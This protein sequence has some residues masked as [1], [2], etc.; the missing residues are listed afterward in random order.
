MERQTLPP[1]SMVALTGNQQQLPLQH[2]QLRLAASNDQDGKTK[3]A[4]AEDDPY[5]GLGPVARNRMRLYSFY[6]PSLQAG[7]YSI[8]A[9]QH[10]EI[11]DTEGLDTLKDK[12][13]KP[14]TLRVWNR[15]VDPPPSP[16][17][18]KD[19]SKILELDPSKP[20]L[21]GPPEVPKPP[22]PEPQIFE[23]MAPQFSLDPKLVDS[24]YPPDGHQDE[25]NTL[26]HICFNDPHLPWER[27]AGKKVYG[28]KDQEPGSDPPIFRSMVPWL[29]LLVF[30]PRELKLDSADE[31]KALG[32]PNFQDLSKVDMNSMENARGTFAM[33]VKDYLTSIKSR[34][35]Y[36]A[37]YVDD[38][39]GELDKT[40]WGEFAD[41]NSGTSIIFPKKDLFLRM[42]K[43][44][45]VGVAKDKSSPDDSQ[46][47]TLPAPPASASPA[48]PPVPADG[49]VDNVERPDNIEAHKYLAHVRHINATGCPDA[50][51]D[52]EG[53]FSVVISSRTGSIGIT[54]PTPQIC[55]LVSIEHIDSTFELMQSG[56]INADSTVNRI[57]LVSLFSWIYMV[58]P[59]A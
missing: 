11:T 54:Q 24:Y 12:D 43:N 19:N 33:S 3:A 26:P 42:F 37:A 8:F 56:K 20:P 53:L 23:V 39:T 32:I 31:A 1:I 2:L 34:V 9:E 55:H 28:L 36:E 15:K 27:D 57:G 52:Q 58:H 44:P 46:H 22:K 10:I 35:Y 17:E 30:D 25:A 48:T 47:A 6:K 45:N 5:H 13:G 18:I 21:S 4:V 51:I 16:P 29:A 41:N 50:G 14:S 7:R 49:K 38:S 40:K 59:T